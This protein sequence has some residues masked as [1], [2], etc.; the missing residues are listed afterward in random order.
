MSSKNRRNKRATN[1]P[2]PVQE[3]ISPAV[4]SLRLPGRISSLGKSCSESMGISF[5][6]LVCVALVEYLQQRG[7]LVHGNH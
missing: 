2:K 7:Y 5:N 6:A 3:N 4:V 1:S